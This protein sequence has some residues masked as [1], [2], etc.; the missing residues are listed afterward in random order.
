M[1]TYISH[2]PGLPVHAHAGFALEDNRR[3]MWRHAEDTDGSHRSWADWN[4]HIIGK[5]LWAL[6]P[7]MASPKSHA[8]PGCRKKVGCDILRH[9]DE[10]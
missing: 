6:G 10:T 5:A 8:G 2:W 9:R 7:H 4:E 3:G 1:P